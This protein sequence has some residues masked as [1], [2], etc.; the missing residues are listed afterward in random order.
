MAL[1]HVI[2][3]YNFSMAVVKADASAKAAA[4]SLSH[5]ERVGV[6]G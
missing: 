1:V 2:H 5:G 3:L 6:R 4:R